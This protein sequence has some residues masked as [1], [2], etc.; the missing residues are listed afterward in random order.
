[1]IAVNPTN[2]ASLVA[3]SKYFSDPQTYRSEVAV[4]WSSDGGVNWHDA[5]RLNPNLPGV[6]PADFYGST[7]PAVVFAKDVAIVITNPELPFAPGA[8]NIDSIGVAAYRSTDGGRDWDD[9][10]LIHRSTGD[11]HPEAAADINPASPNYGNVYVA[12][13]DGSVMRFAR[14]LD[15]GQ[16]WTGTN[17]DPAPGAMIS[18]SSYLPA[19]AVAPEGTLYVAWTDSGGADIRMLRSDDGGGSFYEVANRPAQG[20]TWLSSGNLF[21]KTPDNKW[22]TFD[23]AAFRTLTA[24]T[25]AAG[26][27]GSVSVAW[28]DGRESLATGQHAS[29]IYHRWSND[30]GM[31]WL[32]SPSG[33]PLLPVRGADDRS[34]DFLPQ[35]AAT[36]SGDFACTFYR[37]GPSY[38]GAPA[39]SIDVFIAGSLPGPGAWEQARVTDRAWDPRLDAPYSHGDTGT[40][41]I[42]DYYGIAAGANGFQ[43]CW[44]DTRTGVQD[45]FAATVIIGSSPIRNDREV[46][47]ILFGIINDAGGLAWGPGGPV[48]VGPWGPMYEIVQGLVVY[49]LG[50]R[51]RGAEGESVQ[52]AAMRRISDVARKQMAAGTRRQGSH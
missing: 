31:T 1:M 6:P 16:T 19:L 18:P 50:A 40:L 36:L 17:A 39:G 27:G 48:P 25:C 3:A 15:Q 28:A 35:L 43:V 22:P 14:S 42:G 30:G 41:F 8:E 7:D 9:G 33:T 52:R 32:D 46:L 47:K 13:D 51:M 49:E 26:P 5:P 37:Y 38:P 23:G 45:L 21:P 4:C 29:R 44:T 2:S 11:D 10:V 24:A 20:I 12:W 34:H